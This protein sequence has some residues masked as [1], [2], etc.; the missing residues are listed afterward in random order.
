MQPPEQWFQI[1]LEATKLRVEHTI[2][3]TSH[4]V[5][6]FKLNATR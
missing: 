1:S 5:K 4:P 2:S 6:F 3:A